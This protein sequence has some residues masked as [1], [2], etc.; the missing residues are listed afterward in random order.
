MT[1]LE[2]IEQE[3]GNAPN[4]MTPRRVRVG[5]IRADLAYEISSGEGFDHE[6]IWGLSIV[7]EKDGKTARKFDLSGC[8]RSLNA[9]ERRITAL[10]ARKV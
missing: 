2:I 8:F 9:V 4:I 6:P 5:L 1:A 7:E 10:K 3:Y